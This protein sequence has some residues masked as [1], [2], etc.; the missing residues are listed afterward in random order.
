MHLRDIAQTVDMAPVTRALLGLAGLASWVAGGVATFVA[1]N[2]AG[3]VA[4]IAVGS[5]CGFVA[6]LGR[7]PNRLAV[8]GGEVTWENVRET[9]V[10]QIESAEA[11]ESAGTI[12]ELHSLLRRLEG[13]Q[14]TGVVPL[15]PAEEFDLD[16]QNAIARLLPDALITR[17]EQ[18]SREVADFAVTLGNQTLYVETKWR[19]DPTLTYRA[20]T[21]PTLIKR[22]PKG[23]RLLVVINSVS[24]IAG[25]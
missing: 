23:A 5:F 3:A 8:T 22:L 10:T 13:L 14:R 6:L 4:L 16:V 1:S 7:W 20:D 2:G 17:A 15:H 9:V 18:R 25:R 19:R 24:S 11:T 21:L 12:E